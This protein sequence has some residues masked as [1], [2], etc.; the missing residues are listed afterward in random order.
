MPMRSEG[1]DVWIWDVEGRGLRQL[2]T[3]PTPNFLAAWAPDGKRLAFS[4]IA[5][6]RTQLYWQAAD[7]SGKPEPITR[8]PDLR[9][10][11]PNVFARNGGLLATVGTTDIELVAPDGTRRML[12]ATEAVE[13]N[14]AVS[15]D[16]RWFAYESNKTKRNEI[17]VRPL[18]NAQDSE[19]KVTRDGGITPVWSRDGKELYYWKVDGMTVAVHAVPI[20]A[21][22]KFAFGESRK[23]FSGAYAQTS[24][25]TSYDVARDGRF[26][27][28]KNTGSTAREEVIVVQNWLDE[29]KKLVPVK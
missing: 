28:L 16:G 29:L 27:M 14:A 23:L 25:D 2:T 7:G 9:G 17:Y 6:G 18:S 22:T 15:P 1:I 11:F 20:T 10:E 12:V 24:W 5:Q 19:W 21:E 4:L 13:R 3:D 26:L 8:E